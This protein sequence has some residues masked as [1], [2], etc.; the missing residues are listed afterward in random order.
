MVRYAVWLAT[1]LLVVGCGADPGPAPSASSSP[2]A[3]TQ[4]PT[5]TPPTTGAVVRF[6]A[7]DGTELHG[8]LAG[9]GDT[10][11]VLAN[12]GDNDPTAWEPLA[13]ALVRAG[14]QVLTYSYRY[15]TDTSSFTAA[16]ADQ[17]LADTRAALAFAETRGTRLVL[18]GASLGG[19]MLARLG[20][21][22]GAAALVVVASPPD[23]PD[24]GFAVTDAELAALTMPTLFLSARDDDT[25]PLAA[26]RRLY[27]A[28]PGPKRLL[29]YPGTLH[30]LRLLGGPDAQRFTAAIVGFL[31]RT[32]PPG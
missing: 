10:V 17:A 5:G 12:M 15:P 25:V 23:L 27:A 32:A 28:V 1:L 31:V 16:T 29:T 20:G 13:E 11:A 21:G 8:R 19:M 2:A 22:S 4:S 9:S 26:T 3:S 14:F 18:V 6:T 7:E 24:Y 30:A